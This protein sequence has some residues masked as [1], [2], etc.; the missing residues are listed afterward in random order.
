MLS[1][2]YIKNRVRKL[3]FLAFSRGSGMFRELREAGRKHFHLSWYLSV[4]VVR[5]YGQKPWGDFLKNE[6]GIWGGLGTCLEV[7]SMNLVGLLEGCYKE[8]YQTNC[9][10]AHN[11]MNQ[12]KKKLIKLYFS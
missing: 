10:K 12:L 3:R 1:N 8:K 6:Y 2:F 7:L 11:P 9:M 5:S 4:P